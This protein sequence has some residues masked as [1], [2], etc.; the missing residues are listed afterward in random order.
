MQRFRPHRL[1]TRAACVVLLLLS[2]VV[3][4]ALVA[5]SEW[6]ESSH[7]LQAGHAH[8]SAHGESGIPSDE[9][10]TP[11]DADP[12]HALLHVGHCCSHPPAMALGWMTSAPARA[13]M[14]P[15]S[16]GG[17]DPTSAHDTRLLRP[18][19]AG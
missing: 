17:V 3:K 7:A 9:D 4:P 10:A 2:V 16:P 19:I 8:D 13:S 5:A 15:P 18:P 6:H 1:L 12:W 14:P 11:G